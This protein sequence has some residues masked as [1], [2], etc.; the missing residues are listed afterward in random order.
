MINGEELTLGPFQGPVACTRIAYAK[1][2]CGTSWK[3][4]ESIVVDDVDA[5][6]GHIACSPDSRSEIVVPLLTSEGKVH[7]VLDIDSDQKG[8]FSE[9]DRTALETFNGIIAEKLAL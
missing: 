3:N 7:G 6:P 2:V 8:D 1:G 5:F 9:T 4:A